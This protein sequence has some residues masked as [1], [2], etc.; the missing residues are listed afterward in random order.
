MQLSS[1]VIHTLPDQIFS[2]GWQT[3]FKTFNILIRDKA[4]R[5]IWRDT[6]LLDFQTGDSTA[7]YIGGGYIPLQFDLNKYF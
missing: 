7:G 4:D 2:H 3:T 5:I 6:I 1:L